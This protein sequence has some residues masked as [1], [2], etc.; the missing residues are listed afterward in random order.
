MGLLIGPGEPS[1]S[2]RI[3]TAGGR[4]FNRVW[5]VDIVVRNDLAEKVTNMVTNEIII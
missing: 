1:Q 4:I 5:A 3:L 2:A